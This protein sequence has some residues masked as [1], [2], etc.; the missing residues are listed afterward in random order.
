[1]HLAGSLLFYFTL[2]PQVGAVF[3]TSSAGLEIAQLYSLA[4]GKTGLGA[5]WNAV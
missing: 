2:P 3:W 5:L 1:M 4:W